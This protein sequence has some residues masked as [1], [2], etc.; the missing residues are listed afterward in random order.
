MKEGLYTVDKKYIISE[1]ELNKLTNQDIVNLFG[2]SYIVKNDTIVVYNIYYVSQIE[3]YAALFVNLNDDENYN[4]MPIGMR[5]IFT[6][7][8]G[9]YLVQ[10][11]REEFED[12]VVVG[13]NSENQLDCFEWSFVP[14]LEEDLETLIIDFETKTFVDFKE[15]YDDMR[16]MEIWN[17]SFKKIDDDT[18]N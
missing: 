4:I 1:E 9:K 7:D 5:N 11:Y 6:I 15:T 13:V 3:A 10:I 14:E 8:Y 16:E 17:E 18:D 12:D 2:N